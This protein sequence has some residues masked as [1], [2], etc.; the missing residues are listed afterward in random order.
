[1]YAFSGGGYYS[2]AIFADTPALFVFDNCKVD[3]RNYPSTGAAIRWNGKNNDRGYGVELI[4]GTTFT[5]SSNYAGFIGTLD[6]LIDSST[7][8][9]LDSR[10][11]G[12]NGTYYTITN[13]SN[14]L[15]DNNTD[16]GISAYTINMSNNSTLTAT[17]NGRSGVWVRI[18][19]VDGT[20][21]L[22]VENNGYDFS[23]NMAGFEESGSFGSSTGATSNAGI[24]FWGNATP[25]RIEAGADVTIKN[26]AGSGISGLQGI[27]NLTILSGTITNNGAY[28]A[29]YG[30]GIFT[31]GT[32]TVGPDVQI[33]NNHASKAGDDIYFQPNG[34]RSFTFNPVGS[35]W[36]LDGDKDNLDCNG[37]AHLIDGW[38]D[39]AVNSRWEAHA[40]SADGNH[41]VEYPDADLDETYTLTG[42]KALK[43]AHDNVPDVEPALDKTSNGADAIGQVTA[44]SVIPFE[45]S[46]SV[47]TVGGNLTVT[48]QMSNMTFNNDLTLNN[49]TVEY[50]ALDSSFSLTIPEAYRGQTVVLRYSGTVVSSAKAGDTV[51][52]TAYFDGNHDTV[53]GTVKADEGIGHNDPYLKV[54]KLWTGDDDSAVRPSSIRVNVYH[55]EDLYKT[56]TIY[57]RYKWMGGTYISY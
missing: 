51:S 38:Y 34:N 6:M 19:N 32:V 12:S 46:I 41:A 52:N 57:E 39:D 56:I 35:N 55:E 36:S 42:L 24:T 18:L 14:V 23:S 44:G 49:R 27:S 16:W 5:S 1:M 43:A 17:N 26:N 10:G 31:I 9:V 40:D 54:N 8:N 21:T 22:D 28:S 33:Y 45:V 15:F 25:S 3:I 4:N 13:N 37:E 2:C 30:G 20:S 47:P 48:D 7:L 29:E 50:T 53:L 11:Y